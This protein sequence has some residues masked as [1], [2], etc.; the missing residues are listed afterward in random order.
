MQEADLAAL[1]T[2]GENLPK[3][4]R[5]T[6]TTAVDRKRILRL[7][8][9]EAIVDQTRTPGRVWFKIV[10][11]TG[12][13]SEHLLQRRVRAYRDAADPDGLRR[14]IVDL[15]ATGA[16]DKQV[17]QA[18]NR[19]GFLTARAGAFTGG[20]VWLLRRRWDI[21]TVKI[22]GVE[23]NPPRWVDSSWSIQGAATALGVTPQTIFDYLARGL[24]TGHQ[25]AKEQPWQIDL[26]PEQIDRLRAHAFK[27]GCRQSQRRGSRL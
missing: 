7:V 23:A 22:N 6:T 27:P 16:M 3:I 17:A 25:L 19:E 5:A 13:T 12:A 15:N 14:R 10:W 9:R 8:I 1:R 26:P 18:L 11:Q 24:L 20:N 21:P 4:W 2:I